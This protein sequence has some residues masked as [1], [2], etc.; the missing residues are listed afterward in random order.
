MSKRKRNSDY[1]K[2]ISEGRG[3]GEGFNYKPWIDIQDVPSLGRSDRTKSLKTSRMHGFLSDL[4]RNYFYYLDFADNVEDIREQFPILPIE[5]TILIAEE[6]GIDH[7]ENPKT[8]ELEAITTDF[9]ITIKDFH[10]GTNL[11]ART[12]KFKDALFNKRV[13]EKFEIERIYYERQGIDWGIV[14]ENEVNKNVSKIIADLYGYQNLKEIEGFLEIDTEIMLDM[15]YDFISN[16]LNYNGS[17]RKLCNEFD[18]KMQMIDGSGIA[19]FKHLLIT[20][21]LKI[22]IENGLDLNSHIDVSVN[23]FSNINRGIS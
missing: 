14:T 16:L 6:L 22:N 12:L 10:G 8:K 11:I 23:Q 19:L 1:E 13:I 2:K 20:K 21:E 9:L 4:E 3:S 17:V 18:K 7:P 15:K 5:E